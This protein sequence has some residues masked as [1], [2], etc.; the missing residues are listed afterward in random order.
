MREQSENPKDVLKRLQEFPGIGP[1]GTSIFAR[2]VQATWPVMAPFFDKKAVDGARK[3]GL[4]DDPEDLANL[5]PDEDLPRLA[6]ALVRVAL[7][8]SKK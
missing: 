4:P 1:T 3:L 5:V 2:E 8:R 6:S 7:D